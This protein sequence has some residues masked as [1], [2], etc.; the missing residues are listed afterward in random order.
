MVR[1]KI[2]K[3][4]R[5]TKKPLTEFQREFRKHL[6]IF[7]TGAFSFVAA[8]LWRDAIQSFLEKYQA[9]IRDFF[10][11]KQLWAVQ[12]FTAF[13]V[14]IVAVFFIVIISKFLKPK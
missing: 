13:L 3:V 10:P 8:L 9:Y 4:S 1:I 12:F 11:I 7:I 5:V 6:S 2:K 14:T